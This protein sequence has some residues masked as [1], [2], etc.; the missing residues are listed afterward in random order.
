MGISR[1]AI[2][3][4]ASSLGAVSHR[5][6]AITFGVQKIEAGRADLLTLFQ[7]VDIMPIDHHSQNGKDIQRP[8]HQSELFEMLGFET[9]DSID[10]YADERPSHVLDLNEPVPA[11]MEGQY[12]LVYDGGTMEHCFDPPRVLRNAVLLAKPG[13]TV[14]HHVPMNNWVN[15]GFYQFSPTLFF[16][17]YASCGF[18]D[19]TMK[20]HLKSKQGEGFLNYDPRRDPP[21]PYATGARHRCLIFFSARKSA[22]SN[23]L[24]SERPIQGRY[25]ATFGDE[26]PESGDRK[27][28]RQRLAMSLQKRFFGWNATPL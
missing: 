7:A 11:T 4:I 12:S 3:L 13:G 14:V 25:R 16:D 10:Y 26:K 6:N 2:K 8:V 20:I 24:L 22:Q 1:G 19:M 18:E 9:V 27:S 17:F 21:L 5:G 23:S 28:F 15:H